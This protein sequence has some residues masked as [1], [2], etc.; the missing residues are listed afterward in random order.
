[1]RD[2]EYVTDVLTR[3]FGNASL[4]DHERESMD[5]ILA[6]RQ[7]IVDFLR[8]PDLTTGL[9]GHIEMD[10]RLHANEGWQAWLTDNNY[11]HAQGKEVQFQKLIQEEK[12]QALAYKLNKKKQRQVD[13]RARRGKSRE[14]D[15]S[16][17][18]SMTE[19]QERLIKAP[20]S[21]AATN[22]STPETL[23]FPLPDGYTAPGTNE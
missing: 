17:M 8:Q 13:Q 2:G 11:N 20:P 1:M 4:D 14:G 23:V 18:E 9:P 10:Q 19:A 6:Q 22:A 3:M 21:A 15:T 16:L 7:A 5:T 12:D